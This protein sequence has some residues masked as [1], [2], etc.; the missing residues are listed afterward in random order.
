MP[1]K[2][3]FKFY[4]QYQDL[5]VDENEKFIFLKPQMKC[6]VKFRNYTKEGKLRIPSF[7]EY[8]S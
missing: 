3:K 1:K 4:Q 7:V 2:E 8:I 5:V 6:R